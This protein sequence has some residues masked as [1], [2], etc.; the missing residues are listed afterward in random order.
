[1]AEI[2]YQDTLNRIQG[3]YNSCSELEKKELRRIIEEVSLH[4]YSQTLETLWLSDFK[5]VPVSID[6]FICNDYYLG[7]T[8]RSGQ[9]VYPYWKQTAHNIFSAGNRYSEIVL[10]GATRIGKTSTM[11]IIMAY[12]LYRLMLYRNPH[13]YFKKKE[14]SRFTIAFA[15]LTMKLAEGV[16]YREFNDTLKEC[17][18][19]N[20][21]GR[22]SRSERNFYYI[23]EGDKIDIIAGSDASMFLGMQVW[24]L[25][26]DTKILTADG[27]KTLEECA[28]TYQDVLQY[29]EDG[30]VQYTNAEVVRTKYVTKTI[31]IELEDGSIIEGT[32]E[33]KVMLADGSYEELCRLTTSDELFTLIREDKESRKMK[34]KSIETIQHD[35]P[36]PVYDVLDVQPNHNF[37]IASNS[38]LVSHNC[39]AIDECNFAKSGVKDIGIAKST[40]K[41]LYDTINARISGTFRLNGEVYGKMITSSS[42]NTDCD[43]LSSHIENQLNSG[44]T[45]LYLVDEPQWKILPKEMFSDETFHFTVGDRYKKGFVIPE[46]DDNEEHRRE[47]ESQG[48]KV[49]EAPAEL[50]KNFLADYDIALRDI[51]G[52]SV[53]GSMGFIQQE[54]ITPCVATDRHN[55]FFQDVL[56][57]GKNDNKTI[58]EFFHIEA[59]PQQFK[60]ARMDIHLD[61]AETSDRSGISGVCVDGNKIVD[62][63]DG[64]KVSRPML[65]QV[66]QVGIEAPRGDRQSFQKVVNF[67]VWLRRQGFNIGKISADQY[68]SAYMLETLELQGFDT[69]KVSVDR[70]DEPYIGLKNLLFDQCIELIKHQVQENELVHL[71]RT[72]NKIDHPMT[73]PDGTKGCFTGDTMI[74]LVDGRHLS[75]N[76]L[77]VEH[78][79]GKQNYVYTVNE[80][81][82]EIE[83]KPIVNVFQTKITKSLVRITLDSGEQFTCTPEH[84]IMLR[85]GQYCK[86]EDLFEGCSLMP[87]YT[88]IADKGLVGYRLVYFPMEDAWH[89]EHRAFVNNRNIPKGNVVHHCNYNKLDNS[90]RNL[91]DITKKKHK[92]IHNNNTLDYSKVSKSVR[93]YHQT[94]RESLEYAERNKKISEAVIRHNQSDPE[95]YERKQAILAQKAVQEERKARRK[96]QAAIKEIERLK[97]AEDKQAKSAERQ[98]LQ[99]EYI[100]NIEKLCGVV[101]SELSSQQRAAAA[102]KYKRAT[103]GRESEDKR[104]S[105]LH[106]KMSKM[107]WYTDGMNNIYTDDIAKVPESYHRGRT[108]PNTFNRKSFKDYPED[109]QK[110]IREQ[111]SIDTSNRIWVTD[112]CVDKYI[113]KDSE[114]PEGFRRGRSKHGRNHSVLKVEYIQ[115]P[116]KVYDLSILDNHNFALSAGVFVHNSKDCADALCGA[117][118][119]LVTDHVQSNTSQKSVASA[120]RAMNGPRSSYSGPQNQLNRFGSYN[121]I[122]K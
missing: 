119:T 53:A 106:N 2:D 89:Y 31:S 1:M 98:R 85:D 113:L 34:I 69:C 49:I 46:Q 70:S 14:V 54:I 29:M 58:E 45:A 74:A 79:Y 93:K 22:F 71:Q 7:L 107:C 6:E 42:K 77:I 121:I 86:A 65:K 73:N 57:I 103:T 99:Q 20:D 81:T 24:C 84:L 72:G 43:F 37:V 102:L 64:K 88:K 109:V 33:H 18:F 83:A 23:P 44:N 122:R 28:G 52:I 40:M 56:Q 30:T 63:I 115:Q 96:H 35:S 112:G 10:S 11:T 67:L 105:T 78:S 59:V 118:W 80:T 68:Q 108:L 66:F 47:Y 117:C 8:N 9:A 48:Y 41:N 25:V 15:N 95:Y 75:I 4:G 27:I 5:E 90:P 60:R 104:K 87:L 17:P 82:F 36:I 91:K 50:R 110:R 100:S 3:V 114:I 51:A 111:H 26:R 55:P 13:E 94:Q 116:C 16:C 12:M 19:F 61:M 120:I 39:A 92:K 76:D 32:P 38:L 21:H 97:R 101:W 62:D